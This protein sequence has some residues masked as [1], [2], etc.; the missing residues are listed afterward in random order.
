[1]WILINFI[2][3]TAENNVLHSSKLSTAD[4]HD[5]NVCCIQVSYLLLIVMS[6]ALKEAIYCW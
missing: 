4:N 3:F 5:N 1:M 6:I 2:T